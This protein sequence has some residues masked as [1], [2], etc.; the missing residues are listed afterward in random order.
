MNHLVQLTAI[1]KW[2]KLNYNKHFCAD[3]IRP[4]LVKICHF[5][6]IIKFKKVVKMSPKTLQST[7]G[8]NLTVDVS[9]Q[10]KIS[11]LIYR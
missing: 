1:A 9:G 7:K 2:N 6:L 5:L 4:I 3:I 11:S 8:E 10:N